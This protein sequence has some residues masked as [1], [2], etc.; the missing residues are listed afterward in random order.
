M[1]QVHGVLVMTLLGMLQLFVLIIIHH[2]LV[3]REGPTYG[4]NGCFG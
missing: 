1:E 2:F 4:T 3:L